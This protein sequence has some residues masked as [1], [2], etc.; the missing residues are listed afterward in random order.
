MTAEVMNSC[1]CIVLAAAVAAP[2]TPERPSATFAALEARMQDHVEGRRYESLAYEAEAAFKRRDLTP[3]QRRQMAFFAV[4]GLHGLYEIVRQ[5]ASLCRARALLRKVERAGKLPGGDQAIAARLRIVTEDGLR[6][7]GGKNPCGSARAQAPA[8]AVVAAA[9]PAAPAA[10]EAL[11]PV[12]ASG[13]ARPG[14]MDMRSVIALRPQSPAP[15]TA[16]T[17][18]EVIVQQGPAAPASDPRPQPRARGWLA[19]GG[20][21]V[22][23]SAGLTAGM[24]VFLWNAKL[25]NDAILDIKAKFVAEGRGPTQEEKDRAENLSRQHEFQTAYAAIAAG[26][27]VVS[28]AIGVALLLAAPRR[29]RVAARPWGGPSSVGLTIGGKF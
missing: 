16:V 1:L 12:G 13:E 28:L 3:A 2:P 8:P 9:E 20:V 29:A 18:R 7:A 5:P 23:A 21:F 17:T 22:V 11:L 27:A 4:Q 24:S 26:G 15:S 25:E 6:A 10:E 19:A 14:S